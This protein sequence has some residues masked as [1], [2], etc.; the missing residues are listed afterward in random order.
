M[1]HYSN[2]GSFAPSIRDMN[3]YVPEAT[4]GPWEFAIDYGGQA[5]HNED[6]SL[7]D[8]G[9]WWE[10]EGFL[11]WRD[12]AVRETEK[13]IVALARWQGENG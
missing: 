5:T 3:G 4:D 1:F 9:E 6:G 7:T 11:A 8:Y 10:E 2:M 12:V 13:A